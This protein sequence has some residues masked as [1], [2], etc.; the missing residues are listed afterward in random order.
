MVLRKRDVHCAPILL[1][2]SILVHTSPLITSNFIFSYSAMSL[3]IA[4]LSLALLFGHR[5]CIDTSSDMNKTTR[6]R[7]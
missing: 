2:I 7:S 6:A 5:F 3:S 1:R 4:M